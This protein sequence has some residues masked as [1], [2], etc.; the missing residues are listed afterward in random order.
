MSSFVA[1]GQT[2]FRWNLVFP[3]VLKE[4]C[5]FDLRFESPEFSL[6]YNWEG[7]SS[8]MKFS[9]IMNV[10]VTPESNSNNNIEFYIQNLNNEDFDLAVVTFSNQ[11]WARCG[12][13]LVN[14]F[15]LD[16]ELQECRKIFTMKKHSQVKFGSFCKPHNF[17]TNIS[18]RCCDMGRP[19]HQ[20]D[21]I[22]I[23]IQSHLKLELYKL[24]NN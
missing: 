23:Q 24:K 16:R 22:A 20:L 7:Q 10:N 11:V 14:A 6:D 8:K 9:L 2:Q 5:P 12:E 19:A 3:K 13:R 15:N 17:F 1:T 21:Q 18:C 4:S